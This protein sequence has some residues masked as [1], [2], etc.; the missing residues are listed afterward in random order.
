MKYCLSAYV[1]RE[2]LQK[3]NE[4]KI[5]WKKRDYILDLLEVNRNANIILEIND[6][7]DF[8]VNK[9][10]DTLKQYNIMCG[11]RLYVGIPTRSMIYYCRQA[12]VKYFMLFPI[13]DYYTLSWFVN[14]GVSYVRLAPPLTHELDKVAKFNIPVRAIANIAY[15]DGLPREEESVYGQWIRPEDIEGTY[16]YYIDVIEFA[17]VTPVQEQGLYRIYAEQKNWPGKMADIIQNFNFDCYN[18]LIEPDLAKYRF[19]CGQRCM[20][21]GGCR[22]CLINVK[23]AQNDMRELIKEAINEHKEE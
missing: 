2:Y 18:R 12:A 14:E 5:D 16:E 8:D 23:L 6:L 9:D 11:D 15:S 20:S 10:I 17:G 13:R 22:L 19:K 21:G 4:I 3:A 7:N 1:S